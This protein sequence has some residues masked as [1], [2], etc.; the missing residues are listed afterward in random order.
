MISTKMITK[1]TKIDHAG[2]NCGPVQ[3]ILWTGKI[4]TPIT[5]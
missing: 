2:K 1:F 3:M 4:E 5:R